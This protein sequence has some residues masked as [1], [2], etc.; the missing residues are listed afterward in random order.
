M[1]E[2][3]LLEYDKDYFAKGRWGKVYKGKYDKN[4][5]CVKEIKKSPLYIN[6]GNLF[7]SLLK[8]HSISKKYGFVVAIAN[9]IANDS[10]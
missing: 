6:E 8:E 4:S 10:L 1:L 5:V 9:L 7:K 2:V 3:E